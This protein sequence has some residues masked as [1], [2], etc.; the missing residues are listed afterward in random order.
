M[1]TVN[2]IGAA[3]FNSNTIKTIAVLAMTID[4]LTWRDIFTQGM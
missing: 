4:H 1:E 3:G 2:T